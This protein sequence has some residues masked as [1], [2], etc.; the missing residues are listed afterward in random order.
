M[1]SRTKFRAYWEELD[2]RYQLRSIKRKRKSTRLETDTNSSLYQHLAQNIRSR[3]YHKAHNL[4][5]LVVVCVGVDV[6]EDA[7]V[8]IISMFETDFFQN[9][10]FS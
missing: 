7:D 2:Y 8:S 6:S 3:K 5:N 1:I 10:K 9:Q 4:L